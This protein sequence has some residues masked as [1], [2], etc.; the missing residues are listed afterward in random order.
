M[1]CFKSTWFQAIIVFPDFCVDFFFFE[2]I[3]SIAIKWPVYLIRCDKLTYLITVCAMCSPGDVGKSRG[4]PAVG[5]FK[6]NSN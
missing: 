5:S 3:I 2:I 4:K 1:R 6:K